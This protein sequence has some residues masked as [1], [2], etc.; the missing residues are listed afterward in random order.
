MRIINK[1]NLHQWSIE[2]RALRISYTPFTHNFWVLTD[3]NNNIIDQIHGLAIDPQ[4]GATKGI[5]NSSDLLQVIRGSNFIWSLKPNQLTVICATDQ[6]AETRKR[7]QAAVNSFHEINA[8]QL[9]YPNLWQHFYKKNSNSVF[10]TIGQIM[11][12][13]SPARLLPT[14][15][16]G[17]HLIISQDIINQYRYKHREHYCFSDSVPLL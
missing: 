12:I 16:P 9:H 13:D 6:E 14:C 15:A 5:G 4:T 1:Q 17:I 3:A 2:A 10:N 11:G 8:L 7:W